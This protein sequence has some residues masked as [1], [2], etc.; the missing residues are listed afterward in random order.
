[1]PES[2]APIAL[3][4]YRRPE[5]LE[6]TLAALAANHGARLHDLVIHCDGPKRAEHTA[7]IEATRAV[8]RQL[9]SSG[10]FHSV[11]V[12]E[13]ADNLGLARSIITGVS[14]L[15]R[16]HDQ[17]IVVEDD[18]VTTPH[19]LSYMRDGLATYAAMPEVASIHG[20]A[21]DLGPDMPE[22]FFLR[23]ADCWG[24]ATW[25][26]AWDHFEADGSRL[27]A[28]LEARRLTCDFDLGG[29]MP[30]TSMLRDQIAGR[31]DSW[32]IR[33]HAS[34]FLAGLHTLHPGRSLVLNIGQD[35]SGEHCAGT[36][37]LPCVLSD[38]PVTV[39]P[40]PVSEDTTARSR[41]ASHLR[42]QN[43][44]VRRLGGRIRFQLARLLGRR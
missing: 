37:R 24:W 30:F 19:F 34:A 44:L 32:A 13:R 17:V 14:D 2:A 12:V 10:H 15:V 42:R 1:M 5:H 36:D 23:G 11:R 35:D 38:Q 7:S 33:W 43:S 41:L 18:L 27:L 31:N 22:T 29:A 21:H 39:R 28:Q 16:R 4:A 8:A 25:R 26:R 6:R 40:M 9:A 3:F 20:F